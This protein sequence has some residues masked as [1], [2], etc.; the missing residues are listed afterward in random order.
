VQ[1]LW[2]LHPV[3]EWL[4]DRSL[5]AFGRHTAP[6]L[7][8]AGLEPDEHI[9]LVQ[10]GF[11][12]R[13]GHVQI[14][15]WLAVNLRGQTIQGVTGLDEALER[16]ALHPGRLANRG[17]AGETAPFQALLPLAIPPARQALQSLRQDRQAELSGRLRHQLTV[18]RTLKQRHFDQLELEFGDQ[19]E[20]LKRHK[21]EDRKVHLDRVFKDYEDWLENTQMTEPEP[22]IQVAAL[23]TGKAA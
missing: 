22:Y 18:L 23:F 19:P 21:A 2:D 7:R 14:H 8:L 13:R 10:G 11:P 4:A 16:L 15:A 1:Y 20:H 17:M 5:N 3:M 12:N 6:I 9:V